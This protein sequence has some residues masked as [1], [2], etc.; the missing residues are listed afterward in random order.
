MSEEQHPRKVGDIPPDR[1]TEDNP[2]G[3]DPDEG[4]EPNPERQG[5]DEGSS[6]DDDVDDQTKA[7]ATSE[8][9]VPS[10]LCRAPAK[11]YWRAS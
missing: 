3:V 2:S 1:Q 5:P 8:R 9:I 6:I 10:V 4:N 11:T 7:R